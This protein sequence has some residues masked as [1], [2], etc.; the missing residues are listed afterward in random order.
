MIPKTEPSENIPKSLS[1]LSLDSIVKDLKSLE[2]SLVLDK[3]RAVDRLN[4]LMDSKV[5]M[6]ELE[7]AQSTRQLND[8][9]SKM[10]LLEEQNSKLK[11]DL[12]ATES[13]KILYHGQYQKIGTEFGELQKEHGTLKAKYTEL[14]EAKF[15]KLSKEAKSP[16]SSKSDE[17]KEFEAANRVSDLCASGNLFLDNDDS[18]VTNFG[19]VDDDAPEWT[20]SKLTDNDESTNE[21]SIKESSKNMTSPNPETLNLSLIRKLREN[22]DEMD[23]QLALKLHRELNNECKSS[24]QN[25]RKAGSDSGNK[26]FPISKKSCYDP[27]DTWNCNICFGLFKFTSKAGL[28]KHVK[29]THPTRT[30]FC[31]RCPFTATK[32]SGLVKHEKLHVEN[33]MKF[34]D[35]EKA[36]KCNLCNVW[37]PPGSALANHNKLYHIPPLDEGKVQ[38]CSLK[39]TNHRYCVPLLNQP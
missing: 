18:N 15:I 34:K 17:A 5:K 27:L 6:M 11:S 20:R 32:K 30:W 31:E 16:V 3:K 7:N 9:R 8:M 33:E 23:R 13:E 24:R 25:K 36:G 29:E 2:K 19:A 21:G 1:P 10:K 39:N 4:Q 26:D 37:F 22:T 14:L 38:N 28:Y 12:E 35:T